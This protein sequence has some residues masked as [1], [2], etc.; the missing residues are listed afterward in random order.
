MKPSQWGQIRPS[1]LM[2][3]AFTPISA[4]LFAGYDSEAAKGSQRFSRVSSSLETPR[5]D[6]TSHDIEVVTVARTP[7]Q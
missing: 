1:F 7:G 5:P 4:S 3:A 6:R 2:H